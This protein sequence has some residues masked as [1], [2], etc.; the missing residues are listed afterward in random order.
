MAALPGFRIPNDSSAFADPQTELHESDIQI[1]SAGHGLTGVT[2][3]CVVTAQGSPDQTV[4][5]AAGEVVVGGIPVAVTAGNVSMAAADGSNPRYDLVTVNSSG[6]KGKVDGTAA[7]NPDKP[8]VPTSTVVIAEVYRLT[9]DNTIASTDIVDKRVLVASR[10]LVPQ[11]ALR[12]TGSLYETFT[13]AG[14]TIAANAA[15]V[16]QRLTMVA[17]Q[18]PAGLTVTSISFFSGGTA[19]SVGVNQLFGLYDSGRNL[20]RGSNDDTSTAWAANA[21]KTLTLT[22]TFT[23][24]YTGLYYIGILINATT[25]PNI[26]CSTNAA[27]VPMGIAPIIGGTSNTSVTALPNPANAITSVAAQPW[28]WVN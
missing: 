8:D 13:R 11:H 17:L 24:T 2:D 12:P 22:S 20:L 18:L 27:T 28:A 19:L 5:V 7:A 23:T 26:L 10:Q 9:S 1:M 3:G 15:L 16:S 25:V 21:M 14:G 6:T 4:A